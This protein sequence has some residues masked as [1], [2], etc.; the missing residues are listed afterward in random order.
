MVNLVSKAGTLGEEKG[1]SSGLD[2][3]EQRHQK[4][5][6]FLEAKLEMARVN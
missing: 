1:G 4:E 6:K 2:K 3:V 5:I